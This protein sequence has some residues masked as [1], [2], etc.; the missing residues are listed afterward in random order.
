MATVAKHLF[1]P[2]ADLA[3]ALIAYSSLSGLRQLWKFEQDPDEA[4]DCRVEWQ[5]SM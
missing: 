1:T 4:R 5:A 3:D 2:I